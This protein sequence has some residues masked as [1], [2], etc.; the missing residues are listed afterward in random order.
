MDKI[1]IIR[2]EEDLKDLHKVTVNYI[3]DKAFI[4]Q[5]DFRFRE[6]N[7]VY[8]SKSWLKEI[9]GSKKVIEILQ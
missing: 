7:D 3:Y 6:W 9:G 1:Q 4:G 8:H 5:M 2:V